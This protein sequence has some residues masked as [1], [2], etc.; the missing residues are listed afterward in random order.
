[1]KTHDHL[2]V[3]TVVPIVVPSKDNMVAIDIDDAPVCDSDTMGV[4]PE[5]GEHLVRPAEWRLR[6][7]DPFD[8]AGTREMAGECVVVVGMS[9]FVEEVQ[10]V[11]GKGFNESGQKEPPKQAR[12]H[13]N[14]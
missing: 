11:S 9:E 12:Q 6:V 14:G 8:A 10:S 13:A 3:A 5:I 7:D 4:S 2:M 1:M